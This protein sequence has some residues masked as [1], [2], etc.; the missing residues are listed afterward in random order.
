MENKTIPPELAALSEKATPGEWSRGAKRD[1]LGWVISSHGTDEA[2]ALV[3]DAL[4]SGSPNADFIVAAVNYVRSL[5][6]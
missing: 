4:G 1:A 6:R 2:V 3:R 5:A